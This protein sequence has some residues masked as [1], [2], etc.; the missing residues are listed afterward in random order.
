MKRLLLVLLLLLGTW[1]MADAFYIH[2]KAVLAQHLLENAWDRAQK[3]EQL[4]K[5]WSWADTWPLAR[6]TVPEL[7]VDQIIL[8]GASGRVL[9]FGPGLVTGTANPG[10]PG[11]TVFSGHRDTHFSWLQEARDGTE[12]HLDLPGGE[13]I[14]YSVVDKSVHH[15]SESDLLEPTGSPMLRLITCYPFDEIQPGGPLRY[16]VSAR[17]VKM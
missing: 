15:E 5:P 1:G 14:S 12:I 2:A 13:R 8:S 16:V 17:P 10:I 7:E 11:N 9:A 4:A 6:L 3:G